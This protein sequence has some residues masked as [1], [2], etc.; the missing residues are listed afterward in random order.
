MQ[1]HAIKPLQ[2]YPLQEDPGMKFRFKSMKNACTHL[3]SLISSSLEQRKAFHL[4]NKLGMEYLQ[5]QINS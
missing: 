4:W 2:E 3:N 5:A 1:G